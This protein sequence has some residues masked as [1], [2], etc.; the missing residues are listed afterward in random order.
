MTKKISVCITCYN[1]EKY[2]DECVDSVKQQIRPA[3]EIIL[4]HDGCQ[5]TAK[6]YTGVTTIFADKNMGVV[7]AREMGFKIST[8]SHLLFLD[9]DDVMPLNYL[10]EMAKI[11]ADV[12][13]PNCVVWAGWNNSGLENVWHEAPNKITLNKMLIR[14]EV[15]MPSLFKREWYD[16]VGGFDQSL[17]LFE[18]WDY[19]LKCLSKGAV[20]KKSQAFLMYRQRT[21][22][23]NHQK[24]EIRKEVYEKV[25][26]KYKNLT[27]NDQKGSKVSL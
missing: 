18:D 24:E 23:R 8:G 1:L 26:K 16:K 9:G 3:D 19:W 12:V 7:R 2:L 22:S 14:N 5:E 27:L 10:L 11:E 15:L 20:F 17:P 21:L 6:A 4:V 13:Y 25:V